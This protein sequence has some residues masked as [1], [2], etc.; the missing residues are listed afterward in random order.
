MG[1]Y[2]INDVIILWGKGGA[3]PKDGTGADHDNLGIPAVLL[4]DQLVPERQLADQLV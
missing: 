1:L 2:D 4:P 3:I